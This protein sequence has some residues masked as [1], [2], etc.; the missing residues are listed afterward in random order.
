MARSRR[1]YTRPAIVTLALWAALAVGGAL[2]LDDARAQRDDGFAFS[3]ELKGAIA[4]PAQVV[5]ERGLAE[6]RAK[7]AAIVIV[8]LDTPGGEVGVTREMSRAIVACPLP[9]VVFV[10][11]EGARAASAGLLL[12][13][14]GDVAAMSPGT[15]IGSA[16]PY[17]LA[18]PRDEDERRVLRILQRK[19]RNDLIAF[20][21]GLA[22]RHNRNADL[23][24]RMI[25]HAVNVPWSEA[26]SQGLV[27]VVASN[28]RSLLKELDG[29]Q[30]RGAKAQKLQTAGLPIRRA[31]VV[32]EPTDSGE[33]GDQS[34]LVS[35]G[36]V[37]VA[38]IAIPVAIGIGIFTLIQG[39]G[40]WRRR[41]WLWRSWQADRRQRRRRDP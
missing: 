22:Q 36:V 7:G 32:D 24:E 4:R 34:S 28:E 13:L 16:T 26:S 30:V 2:W 18:K 21:R 38:V 1:N 31:N 27:D 10:N 19:A 17:S 5:L 6:A 33:S 41:R 23:A 12:T 14:S 29:F 9:V 40:V 20:A 15:N 37:L 3:F 11:P 25:S 39:R 35:V 8:R